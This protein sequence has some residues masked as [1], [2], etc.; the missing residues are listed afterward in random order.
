V[1]V[2]KDIEAANAE[3]QQNGQMAQ[4]MQQLQ[5]L[6]MGGEAARA[7]GEGGAALAGGAEAVNASPALRRG[8]QNAPAG[9]V[10]GAQAG[11]AI[12]AMMGQ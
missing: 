2:L 8:I 5:A 3:R 9:M 4:V 12:N 1:E 11:N 7:A 6:Q 10:Q